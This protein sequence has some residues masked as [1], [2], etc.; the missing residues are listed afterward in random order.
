MFKFLGGHLAPR[1]RLELKGCFVESLVFVER[2]EGFLFCSQVLFG[3]GPSVAH[4]VVLKRVVDGFE[5]VLCGRE[6]PLEDTG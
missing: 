1:T 5:V 3:Q 6:N 4:S 2:V